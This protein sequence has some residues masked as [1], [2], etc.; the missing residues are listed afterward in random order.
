MAFD[1]KMCQQTFGSNVIDCM[2]SRMGQSAHVWQQRRRRQEQPRTQVESSCRCE[3]ACLPAL[4]LQGTCHSAT[5]K[6]SSR[7]DSIA[8]SHIRLL[9]P[10]GTNPPSPTMGIC[11]RIKEIELEMARTQKNKATERHMGGLKARLAKL[12]TELLT[13]KAS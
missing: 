12:R 2:Y 4:M 9:S 5:K 1:L 11:E 13:P 3:R 6:S 7:R 8:L 10:Y